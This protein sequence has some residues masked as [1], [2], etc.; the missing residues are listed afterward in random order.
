MTTHLDPERARF[1]RYF[2]T[3]ARQ[4]RRAVEGALAGAGLTDATWSPLIQL[5]EGG[6]GISQT[7]LA[8]RLGLDGSS[9]VRLIDL[10][11]A[12]GF[13]AREVD[14]QDRRAKRLVLCPAGRE[15]V[16]RVRAA[17]DRIEAELLADLDDGALAGLFD[18]LGRIEA[19]VGAAL[20]AGE[21][22]R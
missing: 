3:L 4:W 15:E 10:L 5:A 7:E 14:A 1:G 19:R 21:G 2:V 8:H 9:L 11:E 16:A 22:A 17:L 13:V 18:A 12:R 20:A 6:D